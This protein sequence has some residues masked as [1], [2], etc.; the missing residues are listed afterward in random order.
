MALFSRFFKSK[1]P[2][3]LEQRIAGL[4]QFGQDQLAQIAL[5]QTEQEALRQMAIKRLM[6]GPALLQLATGETFSHTLHT[7]ARKRI[8]ELLDSGDLSVTT[9]SESIPDQ[10]LLL[11]LCGYSSRAG[12]SLLEQINNE[13]LLVEI[14]SNGTTTQLRQAAAQK[15]E[16]RSALEQ[17]AKHAKT[18]DKS[19]YKIVR[20]KLEVF[21]EEKGKEVQ[22]AAEINAICGQAEQLAKRNVDDIFAVRKQQIENAWQNFADKAS[23]EARTRYQQALDKCQQKMDTVFAQEKLA[24]SMRNAERE[25]KKELYKALIGLQEFIARLY[26]HPSPAELESELAEKTAL[27]NTA[28]QEASA[29]G[30]N[31]AKEKHQLR[32]LVQ[33]AQDLLHRLRETGPLAQVIEE[34]KTVGEEQGTKLKSKIEAIID[35][36]KALKDVEAPDIINRSRQAVND[37]A[38]DAK[39]RTEQIKQSIRDTAEMIRKG[40]WAVSQGYVGRARALYHEAEE[41]VSKLEHL[42]THLAAKFDELKMSIQKLG[43]WHEFAVNPKKEALVKQMQELQNSQLHPKDLADKI[44]VLQESWKEL[45]RG[46]QHQDETLWQE[47]HTAAQAAYEPCKRYFEEQSQ[48]REHNAGLRRTLMAQL[49]EYLTAYDW[50]NANWKEVERTLRIS[51]E[52]WTSYWPVP[53]KDSKDLQKSFD[54]LMDQLYDKLN[55]EY[56]RNR[57]KKQAIVDQAK[58]LIEFKDTT[59]AIDGAKKLQSQWQQVGNCRRK[60]DQALWQEFRAYCDAVFDKR[61]QESESLKEERQNNKSQASAIIQK[62]DE[63]LALDG[64]AFLT[65]RNQLEPLTSEF[66]SIGELPREDAKRLVDKFH[67]LSEQ[68]QEKIENERQAAV[69]RSWHQVFEFA[70]QIRQCEL[71]QLG[72]ADTGQAAEEISAQIH[73]STI[74]WPYDSRE[75]LEQRLANIGNLSSQDIPQAEEKL[76]KL[77]IRSEILTGQATPESDKALRMQYQVAHLQQNFGQT[78][79]E[80]DDQTM[81]ELFSEWLTIPAASDDA[82]QPLQQ[83]FMR[84]WFG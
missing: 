62:L 82:Y 28:L 34:L 61:H 59:A 5:L 67:R 27:S 17:L 25:T 41:K 3:T 83:R 44:Q 68:I 70:D 63:I 2:E 7:S 79:R 56:E 39:D 32:D 80:A 58:T 30:L 4:D 46:G 49:N 52:A 57:R 1:Q 43:D 54:Q 64:E 81:L 23:A 73:N 26:T 35:S 14:A 22:M 31:T 8:G 77:C 84:C 33:T 75:I 36:A 60:D 69:T 9:L 16:G 71:H 18:K 74:K 24:E 12:V 45:C 21:R 37:W 72:R 13:N 6:F 66:Q 40:N 20:A 50:E 78:A 10:N 48:I 47:F 42:P 53:R 19:V 55:Q 51:R 76:R 29:K 65:A 15:L 38:A 11:T